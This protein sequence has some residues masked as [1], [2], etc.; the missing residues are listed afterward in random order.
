[1]S[2][3]RGFDA[4][5]RR[6]LGVSE[7]IG[8]DEAGRGPLAGPV[9]AAAVLLGPEPLPQLRRVRD[10]KLLLE[11]EREALFEPIRAAAKAYAVVAVQPKSIDELNILAAT[12]VAMR[13]AV[14]RLKS[15][16]VV[17]VDG[18]CP[19]RGLPRQRQMTLVDGD[20]RSLAVACASILAKVTR[21]RLMVKLDK[22]YPGYGLAQHKG[23]ATRAH[24]AALRQLGPSPIH[25]RSFRPV[26][27]AGEAQP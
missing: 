2:L 6:S 9:V 8:V 5:L 13:R 15:D 3:A 16:A 26:R 19:I 20:Q 14:K 7:L 18:N 25:R 10:S 1:M 4:V 11:A 12:L 17:I 22:R 24:R 23:Y 27:L 21:D